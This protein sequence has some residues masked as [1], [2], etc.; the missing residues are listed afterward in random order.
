MHQFIVSLICGL[1]LE[2]F[3]SLLSSEGVSPSMTCMLSG[4]CRHT[5]VACGAGGAAQHAGTGSQLFAPLHGPMFS[6]CCD[7]ALTSVFVAGLLSPRMLVLHEYLFGFMVVLEVSNHNML[8]DAF[9]SYS[10]EDTPSY[11]IIGGWFAVCCL[12]VCSHHPLMDS[13]AVRLLNL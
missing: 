4:L 6:V 2:P 12:C 3:F 9:L 1:H 7:C 11:H 5:H 10:K 8:H 13:F